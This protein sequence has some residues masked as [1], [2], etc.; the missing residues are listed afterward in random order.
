[1]LASG[2]EQAVRDAHVQSGYFT[3]RI[4]VARDRVLMCEPD[5][6]ALAGVLRSGRDL[7]VDGLEAVHALLTDGAGPLY[8]WGLDL[9]GAVADVERRLGLA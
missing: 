9:P 6:L 5:L 3:S 7:P 4:P 1:M 2:L 8:I